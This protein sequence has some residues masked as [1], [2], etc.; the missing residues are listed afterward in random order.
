[1]KPSDTRQRFLDL[2]PIGGEGFLGSAVNSEI[3]AC[4]VDYRKP[5]SIQ[6][7]PAAKRLG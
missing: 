4:A 2:L 3:E 1:M 7:G 6:N 5:E